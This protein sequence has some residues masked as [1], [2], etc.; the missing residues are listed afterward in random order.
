[1]VLN[2]GASAA[3][4]FTF[5]ASSSS[6]ELTLGIGATYLAAF[7]SALKLSRI[8]VLGSVTSLIVFIERLCLLL[9]LMVFT[10]ELFAVWGLSLIGERASYVES[11]IFLY[12]VT[13]F[14]IKLNVARFLLVAV[15]GLLIFYF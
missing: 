1:M 15:H 9:V 5:G 12:L 14:Y 8:R 7:C 3:L 6:N 4:S 11:I 13:V 2:L 10:T